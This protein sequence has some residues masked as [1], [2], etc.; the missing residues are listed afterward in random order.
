MSTGLFVLILI[1]FLGLNT[2]LIWFFVGRKKEEETEDKGFLYI[3]N[4]LNDLSR[5][6]DTKLGESTKEM[7]SA[8]RT[9]FSESAKIIRDVTE[10]LT[11]LDETNKQV[12]SFADQLQSLQNVLN[13]P[14][15][16]G[17]LGEYFLERVL[18]DVLPPGSYDT[19]Y[20]L[21]KGSDGSDLIVDSVVFV[22][23]QIVP[24]DAK[25]SLENYNRML[26]QK[27]AL[28]KASLEKQ[29]INDLKLRIKETAKYIRP[30][31][32]TTEFAF[33]F[34][35]SEG[36]YYDLLSN[37]VG[38]LKDVENNLIQRAANKYKVIIVSPTT[39]LAYLQTV[40]Q[41]L[42]AM[43][44]EEKAK[45]II[46]RVGELGGHLKKHEE[47]MNK[48]GNSLGTTVN[49]YN[50]ASKELGKIDKDVMR[51]SGDSPGLETLNLDKP[52]EE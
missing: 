39:F 3:Q 33:M 45:D 41:G 48:L 43:K 47:F 49:H 18:Q 21:G 7:Q 35:P 11:K 23:D 2:G 30:D 15:Q 5:T 19:Q 34:L 22:R 36:I 37:K 1:L 28:E 38:S 13:N 14:K 50:T 46:K 26:D 6:V 27:G 44:V 20:K 51:I 29:F 9:Q 40:L 16:R 52:E 17:V 10:G 31:L 8:I 12:V 42:N 32:G 24:V 25:F 4:Q